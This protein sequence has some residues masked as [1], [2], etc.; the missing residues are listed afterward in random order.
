MN[1]ATSN[2]IQDDT[3][4]YD[5]QQRRLTSCLSNIGRIR[6]FLD[7]ETFDEIK[8]S[9]QN[10]AQHISAHRERHSHHH[11]TEE[12]PTDRPV[13]SADRIPPQKG[14]KG[15]RPKVDVSKEQLEFLLH[16]GYTCRQMAEHLSCS[17]S[18]VYKKLSTLNLPA[19]KKYISISDEE[20]DSHVAKL[21]ADFPNSG[22]QMM[23]AYLKVKGIVV[24]R[25]RIRASLNRV[26]PSVAKRWS[27][28]VKRRVYAVPAPNSL[29]HMDGHMKL[30][31]WKLVTHGCI[32]GYSRCVTYLHCSRDNST[33]TVL[34]LFA[35]ATT[36]YG[37]PSR[38]R[39]DHGGENYFVALFMEMVQGR[40]RGS[41]LTGESKHNERIERLWKDVFL[42]V[43]SS[44]YEMFYSLEDYDLLN[45]EDPLDME[46]L[47]QVYLPR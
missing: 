4:M 44:F 40:N 1:D 38:T 43:I 22:Q 20:L 19:R 24:Q 26:D 28:T 2:M 23:A 10:L 46:A 16:E 6:N 36:K 41:H 14:S 18:Y 13:F 30:V 9:I 31:R 42:Q 21:H 47:H 17:P 34:K 11:E 37:F 29:W 45:V 25:S 15:G 5:A 32:D 3:E 39:S 27:Q 8:D 35:E 33:L 12:P 7:S